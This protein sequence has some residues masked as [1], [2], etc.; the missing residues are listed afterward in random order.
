[1]KMLLNYNAFTQT[2]ANIF[3]EHFEVEVIAIAPSPPKYW[4]RYIDEIWS[5]STE[6]LSARITS[7]Y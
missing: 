1:M 6:R 2:L 3:M 7:A 5:F 4:D